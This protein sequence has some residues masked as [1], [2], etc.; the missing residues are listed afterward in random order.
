MKKLMSTIGILALIVGSGFA[1]D[2]ATPGKAPHGKYQAML[3]DIPNLTD[4]QREQINEIRESTQ[5]KVQPQREEMKTLRVKMKEL[6]AADNPDQKQIN[7]LIDRQASVKAEMMKARTAA[8][9]SVR[10]ILTPE[11]LEVLD[12]KKKDHLEMRSKRPEDRMKRETK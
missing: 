11:Q 8:E 2:A 3:E 10:S 5:K 12:Q 4:A 6:K 9:L 1:Q 7:E